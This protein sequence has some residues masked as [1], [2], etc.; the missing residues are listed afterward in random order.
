MPSSKGL[1]HS[2]FS[3]PLNV[4]VDVVV[5]VDAG[6]AIGRLKPPLHAGEKEAPRGGP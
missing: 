1:R 2:L 6:C 5:D 4:V 3:L